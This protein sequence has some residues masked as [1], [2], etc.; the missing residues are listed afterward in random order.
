VQMNSTARKL[1]QH[2][3][4]PELLFI[5]GSSKDTRGRRV[6]VRCQR[7][8]NTVYQGDNLGDPTLNLVGVG[9]SE[10]KAIEHFLQGGEH[11]SEP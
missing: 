2:I 7:C 3:T 6:M 1:K 10:R 11:D 4:D 5:L 8:E 9:E